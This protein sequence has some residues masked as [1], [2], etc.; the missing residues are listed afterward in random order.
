M[1]IRKEIR[2]YREAKNQVAKNKNDK[3]H[4]YN[5]WSVEFSTLWFYQLVET[6]N[7]Q[8]GND[9]TIAFWSVYGSPN[10]VKWCS[11]DINIFY[12]GENIHWN[13]YTDYTNYMLLDDRFGLNLGFDFFESP[14]YLRFPLWITYA[15]KDCFTYEQ[16]CKRC[17]ELRYPKFNNRK[18]FASLIASWDPTGYRQEI[19]DL[20]TSISAIDYAGKWRHNDDSLMNDYNDDKISYL[21]QYYFN[22]CPENS[23]SY[24][25]VTEKC[26]EAIMAGC[27]PIY[28]GSYNKPEDG[29]LNPDAI[30]FWTKETEGEVQR[31]VQM[32]MNNPVAMEAFLTQPRLLPG[33]E[34]KIWQMI[35]GLIFKLQELLS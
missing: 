10:L 35:N 11:K 19:G 18:K 1:G 29:I 16:V 6:L 26:W 24:G 3:L 17:Q 4:F 15:F 8:K 20:L 13:M 2:V 22:I 28:W 12:T 5:W 23:N 14:R 31:K 33:A 9:K 21:S 32:L 27:I 34:E 7:L 30:I 25:Y